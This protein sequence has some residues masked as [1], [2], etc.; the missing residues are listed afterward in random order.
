MRSD[1][2]LALDR[3]VHLVFAPLYCNFQQ[4]LGVR[5][6]RIEC[7]SSLRV[8]DGAR[9]L[10]LHVV[11]FTVGFA[12]EVIEVFCRGG[13]TG[14]PDLGSWRRRLDDVRPRRLFHLDE[15]SQRLR[16]REIGEERQGPQRKLGEV[17]R[18]RR[19]AWRR[20]RCWP[21]SVSIPHQ[22]QQAYGDH[23]CQTCR[24]WNPARLPTNV[25][26]WDFHC[27]AF[28]AQH[29]V[30]WRP[31]PGWLDWN[32]RGCLQLSCLDSG[33]G[34]PFEKLSCAREALRHACGQRLEL[35]IVRILL[36]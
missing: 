17:H 13:R 10:R 9:L 15:V 26:A 27:L 3:L 21:P 16:R 18:F 4:L 23:K 5:I 36:G 22:P 30:G 28:L 12:R 25:L 7:Q 29:W 32:R 19:R 6:L 8:S 11:P 34:W 14:R 20:L 2:I 35:S 33:R 31:F 24:N 1:K